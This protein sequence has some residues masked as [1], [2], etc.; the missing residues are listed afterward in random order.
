MGVAAIYACYFSF[1][2]RHFLRHTSYQDLQF[3]VNARNGALIK[4]SL[5]NF[6]LTVLTLGICHPLAQLRTFK[7]FINRLNFGGEIDLDA[8]V[9]SQGDKPTTGEGWAEM[10]DVGNV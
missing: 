5:G 2:F 3:T 8:I 7:F 1:E 4:L 6:F 10:F 9:Q